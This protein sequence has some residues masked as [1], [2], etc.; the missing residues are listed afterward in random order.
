MSDTKAAYCI[1]SGTKQVKTADSPTVYYL[2][3]RRGIKKPYVSEWAYLAYG[4]KWSDIKIISQSELDSWPDVYLVKTYGDPGVYYISNDKKYLIK[5]EQEFIDFGFGWG[6]IATIHQ[7]DLDSYE[8]VGSPDEIGLAHD[9]QLLVKLDELNPAGVNIPVNTKDNL[10]AVFNFKS[11]DKIVEIYNIAF[12]LKGI[13]NSGI[14]N[15]VYLAD[16]DGSVLVTHYSLTDQRKAAFNFGDSPLTIYPGQESQIKVFVNLADCANCQNHTLQITIN[17]PSDIKVNTGIIACP[18][19]RCAAGGD[20]PLEANIFKLVYAGD[21][22]GRVKAE[23]NL[24]N[25]PE[26]VIGSTNEIIGKFMIYETSN[27]EDALIKKLSFKNKGTVSRSDLVNFKIKNEQGQIIARVSEMN[28][29]NIITFKIPS[30]RDYKIGKNSKKIFTVLGDIAGGEGNT[31]NLQLDAIKAVGAE[32]G[33]TIN[34]SIINLDETLK[35]TRKYL[36]VIAKDLKAG[37]KVFMEQ[38]GTIIG[39]FNIRNNNQEINFESIDFRLEKN[40]GAP[41]LSAPIYLVNYETGE[42][43]D[44]F[45]DSKFIAGLA[46]ADMNNQKLNAKEVLTIT[47][48]TDMPEETKEGDYY[49]IIL[50][51]IN[52]RSENGLYYSDY[53]SV[54][55]VELIIDK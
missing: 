52:Y 40:S 37:K 13:F 16:G 27:K 7:T 49:T 39:V 5:N 29:D 54:E 50:D 46:S 6:Q 8:S 23:E 41:N 24:I 17:E 38:E 47:L 36:R 26:A 45:N 12:K 48:I 22:F 28:K 44:S 14:L 2:D 19:A 33:Y 20:F 51:K 3:H 11:R 34:E 43:F 35:I 32:Y 30:T 1:P 21:V 53:V 25:N 15:K 31:I 18:S 42:V 55:G 4:N 10:I 9:K